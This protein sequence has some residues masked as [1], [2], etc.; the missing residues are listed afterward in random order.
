MGRASP[1]D[2]PRNIHGMWRF[3]SV[4][5]PPG[6]AAT[7]MV[8]T[9]AWLSFVWSSCAKSRFDSLDLLYAAFGRYRS[10]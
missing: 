6:C 10:R 5:A 8:G 1:Q 7:A 2:G 4:R 3:S 9:R